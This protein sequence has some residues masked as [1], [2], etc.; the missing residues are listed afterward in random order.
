MAEILMAP[1]DAVAT[2]RTACHLNENSEPALRARIRQLIELGVT[3]LTRE[4]SHERHRFGVTELAQLAVA[5]SLMKA[6]VPPAV[7][8]RLA[9]EAWSEFVPFVLAGIGDALPDR[10][11]R[12]R[13][14][15]SGPHAFIE[16]NGLAELGRKTAQAARSGGPLPK[17]SV[18]VVPTI[19]PV[20]GFDPDTA[21]YLNAERFMPA[22]YEAI[23]ARAQ[24]PEDIWE[25]LTRL[26][27]SAAGTG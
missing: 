21:T 27:Q 8:A 10:F 13:S 6:R 5:I 23:V 14:A 11:R 1:G 12:L 19:E 4:T 7:A 2:L 18:R 26:R 3:S 24:V 25:S 20:E 17:I 22:I 15:G 9:D 16:G